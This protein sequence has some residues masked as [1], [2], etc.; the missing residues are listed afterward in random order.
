MIP[1]TPATAAATVALLV[2]LTLLD[3][4][5]DPRAALGRLVFGR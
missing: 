5:L 4:A 3:L 2:A 1:R